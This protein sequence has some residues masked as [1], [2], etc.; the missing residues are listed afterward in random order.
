MA[1]LTIWD[2]QYAKGEG[3][4]W[5]PEQSLVECLGRRYPDGAYGK[6]ALELGCGNGR[7]LWALLEAD[8]TVVG[9]DAS[10]PALDQAM[11]LLA[12]R[13]S[14]YASVHLQTWRLEHVALPTLYPEADSCFDLVVDIQ[15]IQHLQWVDHPAVY[16]EVARVLK[17]GGILFT[18]HWA[19]GHAKYIY[20][21]HP[22]LG[23]I[24][25]QDQRD[26]M[27]R[28]GLV[29]QHTNLVSRTYSNAQYQATWAVIEA[30]KL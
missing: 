24:D 2:E 5:W 23:D 29:V 4:R 18:M 7:N 26:L 16:S 3:L 20:P 28:C 25:A 30:V 14:P 22:E 6:V 17:P 1:D 12:R 8:F 21:A 9:I 15:T 19:R 11:R 10:K 27:N 13:W